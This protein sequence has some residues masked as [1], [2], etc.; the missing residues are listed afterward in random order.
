MAGSTRAETP[1]PEIAVAGATGLVGRQLVTQA[2]EGGYGVRVLAREEGRARKQIVERGA[3]T[4]GK[5]RR[6]KFYGISDWARGVEDAEAVVNLAG[7]P[8]LGRWTENFKREILSSRVVTTKRIAGLVNAL[9]EKKRPNCLV[10]ASAIG[11]Y[12]SE[13]GSQ[14][15]VEKDE[16]SPVADPEQDFLARVCSEWEGASK[17]A[18]LPRVV[19]ARFS[20]RPFTFLNAWESPKRPY[21]FFCAGEDGYS[22][23]QGRGSVGEHGAL[24]QTLRRGTDH[25]G[26]ATS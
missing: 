20:F 3:Y 7:Q 12:G 6:V 18:E 1:V 24:L 14:Y 10:N 25:A 2:L 13:D 16:L 9:P 8:L 11:I 5:P 15:A 23:L 17:E 21:G 19:Q 4:G 22:A 26:D